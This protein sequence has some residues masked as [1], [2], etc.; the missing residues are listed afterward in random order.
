[1]LNNLFLCLLVR[2]VTLDDLI[3]N[4]NR[5]NSN[6]GIPVHSIVFVGTANGLCNNL[7]SLVSTIVFSV[8]TNAS[9]CYDWNEGGT[10][11][12]LDEFIES[13]P[14]TRLSHKCV[15]APGEARYW[16]ATNY[17]VAR[18]ACF[19]YLQCGN[20][21]VLPQNRST[22]FIES[23]LFWLQF[24]IRNVHF[25]SAIAQRF[26]FEGD[27]MKFLERSV[28]S[29]LTPTGTVIDM[30]EE[31]F[32]ANNLCASFAVSVRRASFRPITF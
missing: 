18:H 25:R 2:A 5:L 12:N 17:P 15:R 28:R 7:L 13:S 20:P 27:D 30:V 31:F 10:I 4:F 9:F 29:F 23:N 21:V 11:T 26:A 1:M 22:I 14:G 24:L 6:S 3:V 16:D 19:N 8:V 32:L